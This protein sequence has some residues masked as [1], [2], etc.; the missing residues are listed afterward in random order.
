MAAD[1]GV[2]CLNPDGSAAQLVAAF[3]KDGSLSP[4]EREELRRL[5]DE[6]EV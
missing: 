3:V 1:G 5:L 4:Q 2:P 6:M